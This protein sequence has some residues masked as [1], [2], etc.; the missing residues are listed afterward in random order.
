[1]SEGSRSRRFSRRR[2]GLALM[3]A[4]A[5]AAPATAQAGPLVA[6]APN[7]DEQELS[8]PF[9]SWLDPASYTLDNG[10]SFESGAPG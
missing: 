4:V 8:Q 3:A 7:C 10:G 5:L 1:M 9:L 6:S 2:W